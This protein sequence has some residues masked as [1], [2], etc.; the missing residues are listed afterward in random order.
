MATT[1]QVFYMDDDATS[2]SAT[3][4]ETVWIIN[5]NKDSEK[6]AETE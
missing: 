5:P 4:K 1:S 3:N 6:K 2:W